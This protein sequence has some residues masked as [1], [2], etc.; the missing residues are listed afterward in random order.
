MVDFVTRHWPL[1]IQITF[2]LSL[3][4]IA[5]VY[6]PLMWGAPWVPARMR[7]V[8][9]ML[10]MADI[11]PGQKVVDLGAGDGRFVIAAARSFQAQATGVEIDPIRCLIANALIALRGLHGRAHVRWGNMH[12]FD[13][14]GADV[15]TLYLWPSTNQKLATKLSRQLRPGTKVVSHHFSV[16]NWIPV[17]VDTRDR[18]F[19]Y[20][21]GRTELDIRALL[22]AQK[23]T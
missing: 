23:E 14:A 1:V 19:V 16:S 6:L 21:I 10:E 18:I 15:V 11:K 12:D 17:A 5:W 13:L 2:G 3:L 7:V 8:R 22:A 4:G 20:E 9:K